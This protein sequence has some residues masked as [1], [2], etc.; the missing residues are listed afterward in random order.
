VITSFE[1]GE[2]WFY[3]YETERMLP[4]TQLVGPHERPLSQPCPGPEGAVP[5]D[6]ETQLHT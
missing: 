1:P 4:P 2:D 5:A 3:D 6:W